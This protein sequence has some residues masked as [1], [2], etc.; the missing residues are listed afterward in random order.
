[1]RDAVTLE[2]LEYCILLDENGNKRFIQG[3][4]VVFP[5]P[6]ETFVER[7]IRGCGNWTRFLMSTTGKETSSPRVGSA[8][9]EDVVLPHV[10]ALLDLVEH[11]A[12]Y[13]EVDLDLAFEVN[14]SVTAATIAAAI[15]EAAGP[16]LVDLS[17]F[18]VFRGH[19]VP[20]SHR[21]LAYR[22]RL[23]AQDR[24]LTEEDLSGIQRTVVDRA[25]SAG[26]VLR[27]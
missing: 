10:S 9:V 2:R 7:R 24:T 19:P 14:D 25:S 27:G 8:F 21:S 13:P 23:Q 22:L 15:R 3:P 16:L 18:D 6:T 12:T 26:A 11:A 20:D 4:A 17:L 5:A 1:V